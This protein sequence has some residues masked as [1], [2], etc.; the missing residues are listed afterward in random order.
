MT[1]MIQDDLVSTNLIQSDTSFFRSN[2]METCTFRRLIKGIQL[3]IC[4]LGTE[5]AMLCTIYYPVYG[6]EIFSE[7]VFLHEV[8]V[9]LKMIKKNR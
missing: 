7:Y 1:A 4:N 6:S 8:T 2:S 9:L 5:F 3:L